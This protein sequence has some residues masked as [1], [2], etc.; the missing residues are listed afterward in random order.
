MKRLL[1]TLLLVLPMALFAQGEFIDLGL[2]SGIKWS[3]AKGEQTTWSAHMP[4][5]EQWRELYVNC[6]W[7]WIGGG[8]KVIGPNG[9]NIFLPIE[10][11]V[12]KGKTSHYKVGGGYYWTST[13]GEFISFDEKGVYI[14]HRTTS[15]YD[16]LSWCEVSY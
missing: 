13:Y 11:Y 5:V 6:K 3:H 16:R 15:E 9:N 10:G 4:S 12:P 8:Y 7:V 1:L 14:Q 2:P